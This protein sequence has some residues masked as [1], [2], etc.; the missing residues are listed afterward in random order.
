M[1]PTM[2]IPAVEFRSLLSPPVRISIRALQTL[3][4]P[5]CASRVLRPTRPTQRLEQRRALNLYKTAKAKTV[6]GQH[7][8]LMFSS[9]KYPPLADLT[10]TVRLWETNKK[11][12]KVAVM[13]DNIS[14]QELYDSHVKD[15]EM[16]WCMEAL[17]KA[18]ANNYLDTEDGA[19][20][21]TEI[22][23]KLRDFAI[24]KAHL[25]SIPKPKK[26][27]APLSGLKNII[28]NESSPVDYYRLSLDRAYQFLEAGCAVEFRIR[29]Q[30]KQLLKEERY[31]AVDPRR[32]QW[33]HSHFPH[34]RPDFIMKGM[35]KDASYQI[36]PVS[37]GRVV[38]WVASTPKS[39]QNTGSLDKRL[40]NIKKSVARSIQ[41]GRQA[42]LPR[43]L[44]E[45]YRKA[46]IDDYSPHTGLPKELARQKFGAGDNVKYG[47]EEKKYLQKDAETD[48]FLKPDPELKAQ[49]ERKRA[50]LDEYWRERRKRERMTG[51]KEEGGAFEIE[52]AQIGRTESGWE[53]RGRIG[54]TLRKSKKFYKEMYKAREKGRKDDSG[55]DDDGNL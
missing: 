46:G 12:S 47:A 26:G 7:K 14:M 49:R 27:K 4:R 17:P 25:H 10:H 40:F 13:A 39:P 2:R 42:M 35:P 23:E 52:M 11:G 19:K 34:L 32:W 22:P 18:M 21:E 44:R 20:V 38:Q 1:P 43:V 16:L 37:D 50:E 24:T 41:E 55:P 28:L 51:A 30:G 36:E 9:Y 8:V 53:S 31:K 33:T 15:G 45:Q 48:G 3:C 54:D 5:Q 6:L 29:L